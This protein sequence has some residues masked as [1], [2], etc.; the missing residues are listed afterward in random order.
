MRGVVDV[1]DLSVGADPFRFKG[2]SAEVRRNHVGV[3]FRLTGR[4]DLVARIAE[5]A[6]GRWRTVKTFNR[7]VRKGKNELELSTRGLD[8]GR[9]RLTL[10]AYDA[11][12]RRTEARELFTLPR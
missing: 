9:H 3:R 8:S 5:K 10:T 2:V 1:V 6:N 12:N 7:R 4:G 11:A